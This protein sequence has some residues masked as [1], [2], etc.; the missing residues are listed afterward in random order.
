M[1]FSKYY[2][3]SIFHEITEV[4]QS[5]ESLKG[6]LMPK[7]LTYF[8]LNPPTRGGGGVIMVVSMVIGADST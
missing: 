8:C 4:P 7:Y 5:L 3:C 2:F 1:L 6:F